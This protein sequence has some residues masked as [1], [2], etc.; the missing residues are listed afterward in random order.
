LEKNNKHKVNK[1][2][3][4]FLTFLLVIS[5]F[6]NYQYLKEKQEQQHQYRLFLN[7]FY[8]AVYLSLDSVNTILNEEQAENE[9]NG[10]LKRLSLYLDQTDHFLTK[11]AMYLDGIDH[12]GITFVHMASNVIN[13]GTEHNGKHI[14]P[15]GKDEA[16]RQSEQKYL[17]GIKE[18]LEDIHTKLYSKETG[19]ENPY[20]S[21]HT[22][23]HIIQN[24]NWNVN[25]HYL[26]LDKYLNK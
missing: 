7:H 11:S 23:N 20:L 9:L 13:F 6:V 25:D 15:F 14:P 8:S 2:V 17:F 19:Q 21:Q 5:L 16:L 22:F 10:E 4:G 3:I 26:L 24:S 1:V 18:Y 12:R